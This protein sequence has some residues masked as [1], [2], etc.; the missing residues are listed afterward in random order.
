MRTIAHA[1]KAKMLPK[2][3]LRDFS[4]LGAQVDYLSSLSS[5]EIGK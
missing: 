5:N 4:P 3:K 2:S 1:S